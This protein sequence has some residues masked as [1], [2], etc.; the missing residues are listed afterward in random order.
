MKYGLSAR[1]LELFDVLASV[2][3]KHQ[4]GAIDINMKPEDNTQT[5]AVSQAPWN[6]TVP[7]EVNMCTL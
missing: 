3:F 1:K 5:D 4:D 6:F 2:A 7:T